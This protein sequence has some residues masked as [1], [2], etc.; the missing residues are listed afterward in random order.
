MCLCLGVYVI[1]VQVFH[2]GPLLKKW[3][4]DVCGKGFYQKNKLD[5]HVRIHT[6]KA[7]LRLRRTNAD[8]SLCS[9]KCFPRILILLLMFTC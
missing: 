7:C 8:V 6:G 9:P 3:M 1:Y 5:S 4:C 2:G